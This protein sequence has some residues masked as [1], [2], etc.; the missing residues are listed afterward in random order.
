MKLDVQGISWSIDDHKIVD[1]VLL[2]VQPGEFVG[3][4]GPNGSGKS[5][6]LRT[7]YRVL[8]PDAGLITLDGDDIWKLP[9]RQ[10]AQRTA[11]VMQ[12]HRSEFDCTV[13]EMVMLGRNP[14][15]GLFDQDTRADYALAEASLRQV[16]M[17]AFAKRD[18]RTLSGGEKQRV[19][20]ARALTQQANFLVLD[21]PTNHL[22]IR[23]QLEILSLIKT[24][25][26]TSLAALHDLNLAAHYCDRLFL[27]HEG[28]IVASGTPEQVLQPA[29]IRA[30]YHVD[31]CVERHPA[32]K[33]LQVTFFPLSGEL[34][35]HLL[36]KEIA[37]EES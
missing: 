7:I 4:L 8:K 28:R 6:L 18:F 1:R 13:L 19:L 29:L 16:N 25:K 20:V 24:L 37:Q 5:S 2:D 27:L 9:P 23:Y 33:Q 11:V 35:S 26:I 10:V 15:K 32:T 30:V 31:T 34:A 22:D 12:E 17:L 14:H 21:E 36:V 3:L